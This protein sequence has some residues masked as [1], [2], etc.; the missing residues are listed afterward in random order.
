MVM[1]EKLMAFCFEGNARKMM[2]VGLGISL[3]VKYFMKFV[4]TSCI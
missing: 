3:A 4:A 1:Y 2:E